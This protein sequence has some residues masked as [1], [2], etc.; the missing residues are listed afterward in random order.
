MKTIDYI[1]AELEMSKGWLTPLAA[2]MADAPLTA[3]TP[4]GGNH[5]LWVMGHMAYSEA[6]LLHI[7][8]LGDENPLAEWKDMFAGGS[9]PV[10]DA[11][12]YPAFEEVMAKFDAARAE[13]LAY[14]DTITEDDLDKSS[15]APEEYQAFFGNVGQVLAMMT[16]HH[17][18]H[19]G[20]LADARRAA[21]R[22]VLMA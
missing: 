7:F 22:E 20:Q 21:L 19:G 4:N 8:I 5:P 15:L 12:A 13:T 10:D 1:K 16:I 3:P 17:S 6:N 14:L 9:Q 18:F 11:A 2:D